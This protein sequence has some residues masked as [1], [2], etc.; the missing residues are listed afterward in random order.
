VRGG[1]AQTRELLRRNEAI[2]AELERRGVRQED[3][4]LRRALQRRG[5]AM[6]DAEAQSKAAETFEQLKRSQFIPTKVAADVVGGF[7]EYLRPVAQFITDQRQK[8]ANGQMTRRDVM[9]AYA[10]TVA[11]QGSG[12]RAVEVIANNVAKDGIKFRPSKDFTTADKQG[13]AAIRPEE[14]AAYWLGTDAG[15]RALNNFEAG[16]FSPDDWKELVAI[17][18]AYGDDRFNNLGAFNPD[19][20]RTMDK[21]LADLNASRAD[22]GKVMDAVQQLRGIKTGKKGFIAHLL[23][24]G[25][26]P[27]IDAVEINFWLTGKADIGKL[28]TRKATLARSVKESISDR[29][30][31]QEMFRRIDQRINA[32]RDEVPGGADIS[33]EVWSHVMHHWLWD[34][35]KGIET[36]HEGMYR[37]QAQF[38]PDAEYVSLEQQARAG[39]SA[40]IEAAQAAVNDAAQRAGLIKGWHGSANLDEIE[41]FDKGRIGTKNDAGFYGR[42]FYFTFGDEKYSPG[43]AGYYGS[44]VGEFYLQAKNPFIFSDLATFQGER[45]N[46]MG[47]DSLVFLKNIADRFPEIGKKITVDKVKWKN[48]EGEVTPINAVT[49]SRMIDNYN[50]RIKVETVEDSIRGNYKAGWTKKET[51]DYDYTSSG[52]SKGSFET[53]NLTG[54]V[55]PDLSDAETKMLLIAEFLEKEHGIKADYHPEGYMTRFPE[56]TKAI[57]DKGHDAIMQGRNGD[58]IVVFEPEQIKSAAAFTYDKKGKPVPLSKR[59]NFSRPEISYGIAA[60]AAGA[61][62]SELDGQQ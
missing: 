15:Q 1:A 17:R 45:I 34:K 27:T 7:P 47:V 24:I 50:K 30:V 36:T 32:L 33:P 60:L 26:V 40:A 31:S 6:P 41:I 39:D 51:V 59:F 42:G 21:V 53:T 56:I 18:K 55:N 43:E 9:K 25:D 14:A 37:A 13:R 11:S 22:T 2:S 48:G 20:I 46:F 12:A 19:N 28:N 57:R 35:S 61:A 8:L 23:G 10:M 38:M 4:Q 54:R 16:R 3:P 58:E 44:K 62:M 5:Q 29:R 49:L 52:G